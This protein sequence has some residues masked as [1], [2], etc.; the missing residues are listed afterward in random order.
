MVPLAPYMA[1]GSLA[2]ALPTSAAV[3]LAALFVFG[4]CKGRFT[5]ISPLRGGLQTVTI[6][7]LASAAAYVIARL[8]T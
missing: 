8:I 1:M 5:G 2:R 7:G 3:T 6:G 4:Y